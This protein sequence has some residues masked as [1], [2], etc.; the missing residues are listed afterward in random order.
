MLHG[1]PM[2]VAYRLAP[3]TAFLVR[4]LGLVQLP[5]FSLP[6][7]LAGESLVPEY[8]QEAVTAQALATALHTELT[9]I[10]KRSRLQQ[11]FAAM[12]QQLRQGGAAKAAA[13]VLSSWQS[14][15]TRSK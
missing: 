5:H 10:K 2:V 8:F 12:H 3:V 6:N 1:V 11:R 13:L 4:D 9:D 7:L 15:T 14:N